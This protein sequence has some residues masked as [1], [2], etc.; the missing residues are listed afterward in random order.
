MGDLC[1]ERFGK[2]A[3]REGHYGSRRKNKG[4]KNLGPLHK[5]DQYYRLKAGAALCSATI[6]FAFSASALACGKSSRPFTTSGSDSARTFMP[7]SCPNASMKIS[8]L[9]LDLSQSLL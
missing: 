5:I 8:D 1:G 2:G 4:P 3:N 9:M 7:S 6:F